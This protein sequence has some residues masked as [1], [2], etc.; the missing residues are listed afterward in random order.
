M[1][2]EQPS[3][4][5]DASAPESNAA[6]TICVITGATSG[7]GKAT[8]T[9]LAKLGAVVVMVCR[10]TEAGGRV[11]DEIAKATGND[12]VE[13]VQCDL[14]SLESVRR[15]AAAIRA[16]HERVDVLINNAGIISVKRQVTTDGLERTFAVNH[17]GHFLLTHEL[18]ETLKKSAPARIINVASSHHKAGKVDFD[19]LQGERNYNQNKAY[20]QSK[21]LNV[22][23]TYELAR[24]LEGS[25]VTSNC[26]H[27]G[28]TRTNFV[29]GLSGVWAVLWKLTDVFRKPP[30]AAGEAIA[31]LATSPELTEVTGKYFVGMQPVESSEASRVEADAARL[32]S[33]SENLAGLEA[34]SG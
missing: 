16:R 32:W 3:E 9:R 5:V 25:G 2:E 21:L 12:S 20:C 4:H 8:A 18:V 23:F 17:L 24:R 11:R 7:I 22:L 14:S 26:L 13:V 19:D 34:E 31:H 29:S 28:A 33:V 1:P 27:P 30:E 10:D 6:G 15:L